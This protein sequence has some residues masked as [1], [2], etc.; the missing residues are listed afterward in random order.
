MHGSKAN[1]ILKMEDLVGP[2]TG[3]GVV[4]MI[5]FLSMTQIES[6]SSSPQPVTI[7]TQSKNGADKTTHILKLI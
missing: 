6:Q 5:K 4:A 2:S 7:L 3:L 1:G